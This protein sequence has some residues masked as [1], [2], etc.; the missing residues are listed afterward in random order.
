MTKQ[1]VA[2]LMPYTTGMGGTETVVMNFFKEY[3]QDNSET[4]QLDLFLIGGTKNF[5]W[6]KDI[7]YKVKNLSKIKKI[8]TVQYMFELPFIIFKYIRSCNPDI[9]ISTNPIMWFLA[10]W[11]GKLFSKKIKVISWYHYSL[12][13]KDIKKM[14]IKS[15]DYYW[16]ISSG[17][18]KELITRGIP[19]NKI[20]LIY[21]PMPEPSNLIPKNKSNKYIDLIYIGR[22]MLDGQKNLRELINALVLVNV[23]WRLTIYGDGDLEECRELARQSGIE[24]KITWKGFVSNPWDCIDNADALIL[25]SKFEGLPMVIGEAL[26]HGIF[27]ISSN[28]STGPDDLISDGE[29][30]FLYELGNPSE[31]A[32]KIV[33]VK[34]VTTTE[35]EIQSS[36]TTFSSKNYYHNIKKILEVL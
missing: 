33:Q 16:A 27:C 11:I 1:K 5:E 18:R 12:S 25:T 35:L 26:S 19:E 8:R 22:L 28:C 20:Y 34:K 31:L 4:L 9:I 21:N 29:N 23:E 36:I 30:G 14:M 3:N 15:A 17:I 13:Q 10:F 7:E 2:I 32:S 6:L 24:N